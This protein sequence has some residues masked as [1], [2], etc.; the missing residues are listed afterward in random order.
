MRVWDLHSYM[1]LG[2]IAAHDAA[3]E[4]LLVVPE[5]GYLVSCSTDRTV[6]VWDYGL[7]EELKTWRHPEE[8]RCV[9]H[10]RSTNHIVAGTDQHSIVSFPLF[11]VIAEQKALKEQ[12]AREERERLEREAATA[13]AVAAE[14][15]QRLEEEA[16]EMERKRVEAEVREAAEDEETPRPGLKPRKGRR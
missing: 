14:E 13:A 8:F 7:G 16:A 10:K 3:V 12:R 2:R 11:E 9:A 15:R 6:R 5:V 4:G 1:A